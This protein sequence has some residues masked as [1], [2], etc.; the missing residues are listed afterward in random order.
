MFERYTEHGRQAIFFARFE[1]SQFGT[2]S[3]EPEHL[4]LGILRLSAAVNF[5]EISDCSSRFRKL[6]EGCNPT[7]AKVSTSMDIPLSHS[8]RRILAYGSEE[9]ERLRHRYID[10]LHLILG[11]LREDDGVAA[12]FLK[13]QSISLDALR[14]KLR[15]AKPSAEQPPRQSRLAPLS[16]LDVVCGLALEEASKLSQ[17]LAP[18]H[19]LLGLLRHAESPA[20]K[21]LIESGLTLEVIRAKLASS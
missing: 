10:E 16:P 3:I 5:L 14:D 2:D 13:T 19:L 21:L 1:A 8:S 11:I 7:P 12:H 18:Q 15:T 9:A 17:P 6:V 4:L 20:A